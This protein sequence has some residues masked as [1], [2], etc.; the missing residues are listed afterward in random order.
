MVESKVGKFKVTRVVDK[1]RG[2]M[3]QLGFMCDECE[4]VD[5]K[6]SKE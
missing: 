6:G 4:I 2:G 3:G 5:G 1:F